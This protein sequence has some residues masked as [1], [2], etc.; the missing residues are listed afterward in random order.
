MC[1]LKKKMASMQC[2]E[3]QLGGW[4][5]WSPGSALRGLGGV[6]ACLSWDTEANKMW[7]TEAT[8]EEDTSMQCSEYQLGEWKP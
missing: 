2:P 4:K 1:Q 6:A 3:Y 8:E 7:N 5:S